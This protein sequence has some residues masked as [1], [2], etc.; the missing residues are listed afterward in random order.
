MTS[1]CSEITQTVK[2]FWESKKTKQNGGCVHTLLRYIYMQTC[3]SE[4]CIRMSPLKIKT[5]QKGRLTNEGKNIR[6]Y[7]ECR[8]YSLV[9]LYA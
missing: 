1:Y 2:V 9:M 5:S 3:K 6:L 4:F 7:N 8:M